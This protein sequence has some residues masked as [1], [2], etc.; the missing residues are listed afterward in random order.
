MQLTKRIT[1]SSRLLEYFLVCAIIV[2]IIAV[3]VTFLQDTLASTRD[4]QRVGDIASLRQA[5][6]LYFID[7]GSYPNTGW[8]NS[9]DASWDKLAVPL[10]PYLSPLPRDPR[11]EGGGKVERD[12]AFNYSYFSSSK[13]GAVGGDNDY[14]LV[15]RFERPEAAAAHQKADVGVITAHGTFTF[16]ELTGQKGLQSLSSP[17]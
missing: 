16:Y 7:H 5:L 4:S 10:A 9:G 6:E 14:V 13:P 2:L 15:F 3:A 11:N 8:I 17:R 12:G 1:T